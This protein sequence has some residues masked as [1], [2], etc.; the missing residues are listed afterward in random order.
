MR[1]IALIRRRSDTYTG[2]SDLFCSSSR[3]SRSSISTFSGTLTARCAS[4]L[5]R[6]TEAVSDHMV[7]ESFGL[8]H[9]AVM[10]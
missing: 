7:L 3:K 1:A 10:H 9:V 2:G 5:R 4:S 6:K 8:L